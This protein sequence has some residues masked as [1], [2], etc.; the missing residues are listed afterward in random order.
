MREP[1]HERWILKLLV[2]R[3]RCLDPFA[4]CLIA[5]LG[6]TLTLSSALEGPFVEK[7][8]FWRGADHDSRLREPFGKTFSD[9]L[10]TV[11]TTRRVH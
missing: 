4:C 8:T 2:E 5:V 11:L 10:E 6:T 3:H 9:Y 1:P 7:R